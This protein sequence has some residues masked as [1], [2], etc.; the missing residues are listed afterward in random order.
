M[1]DTYESDNIVFTVLS[2]EYA[3][4]DH[5]AVQW[6]IELIKQIRWERGGWPNSEMTYSENK[7]DLR[8]HLEEFKQWKSFAYV[9]Y[10]KSNPTYL[11]CVYLYPREKG[12]IEIPEWYDLDI[13]FWVTKE[14]IDMWLFDEIS[15]IIASKISPE[16]P[17]WKPYFSNLVLDSKDIK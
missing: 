16:N 17:F 14:A 8:W 15:Q 6:N 2:P 4:D 3:D 1:K 10:S 9:I 12:F 7:E 13:N 11:G 5:E